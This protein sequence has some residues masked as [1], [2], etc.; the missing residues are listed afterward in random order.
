MAHRVADSPVSL[1]KAQGV[2]LVPRWVHS[3]AKALKLARTI[4]AHKVLVHNVVA[5][6]LVHRQ[7]HNEARKVQ[8]R[9]QA[10]NIEAPAHN[11]AQAVMSP[12]VTARR[13]AVETL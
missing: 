4:V 9:R 1:N 10:H 8:V 13:R 12:R 6:V 2:V 3:A 11:V 7:T 5:K